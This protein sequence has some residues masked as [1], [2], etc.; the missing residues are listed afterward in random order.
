MG[1]DRDWVFTE[2]CC[3]RTLGPPERGAVW[4]CPFCDAPEFRVRESDGRFKC[5]RCGAW[6]DV[7]DLAKFC[8]PGSP[9]GDR[10]ER[11]AEWRRDFDRELHREQ[12]LAERDQAGLR[13]AIQAAL[14]EFRDFAIHH[15][16]PP[17]ARRR[18]VDAIR[19]VVWATV[20][21][22][23]HG[24]T[25]DE[26]ASACGGELVTLRRR[27]KARRAAKGGE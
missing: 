14:A 23:E 21:A 18:D 9:F 7:L 25:L 19:L 26:L 24:I 1:S 22:D 27:L 15:R 2:F 11:I 17:W 3:R 5:E 13:P 20:I 16:R 10:L 6:G 4:S 12:V 8:F